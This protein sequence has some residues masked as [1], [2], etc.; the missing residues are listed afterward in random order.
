MHR[1]RRFAPVHAW[2][3]VRCVFQSKE[4][5]AASKEL[6]TTPEGR[7][8]YDVLEVTVTR[9]TTL[10]E[11]SKQFRSLVVKYHPDKPGGS[12]EKMAEVNL[13]YKIVKE[14]HDAMLRRMKEAESTIKANEAY[15]QHKHARASR[16]EDLG[17]SGG[18]NRRNS[19]ATR[20][21]AEPTGLRRTRS[22]KEIE[23]QWAKYKED[24]E[25]AVRSMC[26]RYELAIQQGKFFRKSA[27]LNEI[28]VRERWLRKSFAKGVWED[29]HELRGELLRRGT[30]SA[31]QSELAEEMVSFASTTQR[32]LNE[33]F[34]R[35]TQESVQLQSR[36]LV[37]RVFFMVCSVIL[38]VKVWRWFVGF[39]FNNTL[40]VKLKRGFLSQ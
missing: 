17:R 4:F 33:N 11:V 10:D 34:Q 9:A 27:T 18:L 32:K 25:A 16:D 20:E 26:N 13:A 40:T 22:L 30:R 24:T 14:N 1:F 5:L 12:T 39:T 36:M 35:L 7:N 21:A 19:R 28:T 31:Q 29:V 15:R 38:L 6:P 2:T 8:P 37:E 3:A 23:A